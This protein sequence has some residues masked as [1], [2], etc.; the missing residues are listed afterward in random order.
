[1]PECIA[2]STSMVRRFR[3][4][5]PDNWRCPECGLECLSPQPDD[6]TLDGIYNELYFSH[7]KTEMDPGVTRAMKRA[8]YGNQF[9]RLPPPETFGAN[10]R[11]LDCGAATGFLVG[12]AKETGWDAYAIEISEFGSHA[13][14]GLLGQEKVY[15]GEVQDA[16][17]AANPEGQ[18]EVITMFD[19]IEHVRN[20]RDVLRSVRRRLNQG[21]ILMMTTPQ[22]GSISWHLMGRHWFHYVREHLWFFNPE[23]IRTLLRDSGFDTVEIHALRKAVTI[24]YAL[25]HYARKNSQSNLFSPVARVL[26]GFLPAQAKRIRLWFYLGEMVI[27]ARVGPPTNESISTATI[28][29][30]Q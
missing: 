17:F 21:S 19:F 4:A 15:R 2:C 6:Q 12:L 29:T 8:T 16:S 27:M 1:M 5:S 11:L 18:F 20:P 28:Q 13:C 10:R 30:S 24:D 22:A 7:Y 23:S 3:D 9:R 14:A 26:R 25:A